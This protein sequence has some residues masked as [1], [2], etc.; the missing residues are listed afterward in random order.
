LCQ[1]IKD[2]AKANRLKLVP[3]AGSDYT[4]GWFERNYMAAGMF[5]LLEKVDVDLDG[6]VSTGERLL[7]EMGGNIDI[8]TDP[9]WEA[10]HKL[11]YELS[12]YYNPGFLSAKR[13]QAT[14]LFAQGNA[15]MMATGTWD[16]GSVWQQV[17][18]DFEIMIFDFPVPTPGQKYYDAI[19]YR[20]SE[21]GFG[22][23][24]M[25]GLS[26]FSRHPEI[27]IDFMQFLTS[28]KINEEVNAKWRWFPAIRGAKTDELLSN[29][30]P[31]LVGVY[32]AW[33]DIGIGPDTNIRYGQKHMAYISA[34]PAEGVP[35]DPWLDKHYKDFIHSIKADF[36]Q[37]AFDDFMT[38][39]RNSYSAGVQTEMALTQARAKA[40]REGMKPDVQRNLLALTLGQ[41]R[42]MEGR[43]VEYSQYE[44]AKAR[45]EGKKKE[46]AK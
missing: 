5:P 37:Y 34:I 33:W 15:A 14:F 1:K 41:V 20:L 4:A 8:E 10:A 29:F 26:K 13:D 6:N 40:M 42:R 16:A 11:Q 2:Y 36:A 43:A 7:A 31:Q 24:A 39:W 18:G 22:A 3:I 45:F 46:D 38:N 23:S 21:A 35:F 9:S 17:E 44:Q 27:A 30:E 25:F 12:R 19:K 28:L 32:W